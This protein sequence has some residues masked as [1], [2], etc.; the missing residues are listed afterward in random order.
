MEA[1]EKTCAECAETVKAAAKTCKHCGHRFDTAPQPGFGAVD[2]ERLSIKSHDAAAWSSP[3]TGRNLPRDSLSAST[4]ISGAAALL[5]IIGG[6]GYANYREYIVSIDAP[7]P[8][9]EAEGRQYIESLL[10]DPGSAQ[11]RKV[12]V[13][14]QCVSGEVNGKNAFG[15]YAGFSE[16][17]YNRK[18]G[19]GQIA[20]ESDGVL[21][22]ISPLD[23]AIIQAKFLA[24]H[25]D[26]LATRA[27]K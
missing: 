24:G 11:F 2:P 17:Y 12:Q 13:Q 25:S 19:M 7:D 27:P 9:I 3:P 14:G 6:I 18:Q 5:V 22:A 4:I 8:A 16:F 26:C 20:P 21:K 15:G 10:S 23:N 1:D